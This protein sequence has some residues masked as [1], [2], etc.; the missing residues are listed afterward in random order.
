MKEDLENFIRRNRKEF[1]N[2]VPGASVWSKLETVVARKNKQI[3]I[4]VVYR[5]VAAAAVII[6]AGSIFFIA[7]RKNSHE[8]LSSNNT[9]VKVNPEDAKGIG[10]DY[11]DEFK[12][13]YHA[14]SEKQEE[15]RSTT[16]G[17][18]ELYRQFQK[19]MASLDS[20]Y[21]TLMKQAE[22]SPN[23]DILYEAIIENLKLRAELLSRQLMISHQINNNKKTSEHE[24]ET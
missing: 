17:N 19:D 10:P 22:N 20:S 11:A 6:I 12:A 16:A 8:G 14:I 21:Q 7:N 15:L 9:V 4:P 1:D 13:V 2:E 24:K 23:Q 18:P 5:W 3:Y